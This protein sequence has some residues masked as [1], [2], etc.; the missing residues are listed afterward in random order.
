MESQAGQRYFRGP[1][2]EGIDGVICYFDDILLHSK[3]DSEHDTLLARVTE[4]LRDVG[5]QLNDRKYEY[6]KSEIQFLGH[7]VSSQG[8]RP[9]PSKIEATQKIEEPFR[10]YET[11]QIF[12]HGELHRQ[13]STTPVNN[14]EAIE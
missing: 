3:T 12:R 1:F 8:V 6:T 7:I 2:L 5:L 10:C 13:V 14:L 4:R 9:E 11:S